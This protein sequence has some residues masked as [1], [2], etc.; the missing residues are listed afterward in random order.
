MRRKKSTG[1][2]YTLAQIAAVLNIS[3]EAVRQILERAIKKLQD[4]KFANKWQDIME[5]MHE[6]DK[7]KIP[8]SYEKMIYSFAR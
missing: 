8:N 4:P 7:E 2:C 6:I 5:T 1:Y 3:D